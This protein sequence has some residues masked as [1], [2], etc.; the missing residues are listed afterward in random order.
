MNTIYLIN[1]SPH[2]EGY[3]LHR[4][5]TNEDDIAGIAMDHVSDF[6][7]GSPMVNASVNMRA[8]TVV[9]YV[10]YSDDD[11][12]EYTYNIREFTKE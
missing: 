6:V 12:E 5:A 4:F 11:S 9:V 3:L 2:N 8:K 1:N 7:C 10:I